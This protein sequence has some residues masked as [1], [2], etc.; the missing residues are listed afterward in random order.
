M[1]NGYG[2]AALTLGILSIILIFL[3]AGILLGPA[4]IIIGVI[5]LDKDDSKGLSIAGIVTG[6]IGTIFNV[7]LLLL[8]IFYWSASAA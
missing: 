8:I 6:V 7:G 3:F 5:G 2:T 4:A 1:G